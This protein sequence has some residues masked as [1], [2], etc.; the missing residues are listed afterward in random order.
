M[1]Q[2]SDCG[3]ILINI[4]PASLRDFMPSFQNFNTPLNELFEIF[5]YFQSIVANVEKNKQLFKVI[6][7]V[8]LRELGEQIHLITI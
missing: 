1:T 6:I 5:I 7:I 8:Q 3:Q 2:V 4:F